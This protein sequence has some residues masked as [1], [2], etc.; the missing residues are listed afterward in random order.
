MKRLRYALI[1]AAA[2]LLLGA[3]GAANADSYRLYFGSPG[4]S[5]GFK[6]GYGHYGHKGYYQPRHHYK[7]KR[8][9]RAPPRRYW[10]G[11][12]H[13]YPRYGYRPPVRYY[14]H[15]SWHGGYRGHKHGYRGPRRHGWRH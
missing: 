7:H 12:G 3:G 6:S 14:G 4:A 8:Y 2:A 5:I 9:Y 1:P 13:G 15:K 10:H 11:H